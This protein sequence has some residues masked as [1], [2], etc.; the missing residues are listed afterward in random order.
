MW[1]LIMICDRPLL[2]LQI[3]LLLIE[4]QRL[5]DGCRPALSSPSQPILALFVLMRRLLLALRLEG[6]CK[7]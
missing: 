5:F 7:E 4:Y 2:V 1:S 3:P 6:L